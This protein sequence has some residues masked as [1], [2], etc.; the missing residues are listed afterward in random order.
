MTAYGFGEY[1][2]IR[3]FPI[4]GRAT[5]LHMRKR[6]WLYRGAGEIFSYD[7]DASEFDGTRLNAEFAAFLKRKSVTYPTAERLFSDCVTSLCVSLFRL[8]VNHPKQ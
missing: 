7:C 8:R 5:Y 4:C 2:T 6:K 1:H 3:D